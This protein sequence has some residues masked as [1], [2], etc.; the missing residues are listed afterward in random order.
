MKPASH[1]V[2][3]RALAR[4]NPGFDAHATVFDVVGGRLRDRLD[5]LAATPDR[6]LDLGCRTG[7]QLAALA[8]CYP[9]AS[10]TG[11]DPAPAQA[12]RLPSR[13]PSWL[14]GKHT[15]ARCVCAD[16]HA[17][18]FENESFDLVVSNLALPWCESPAQ[19]FREVSRVLAEDGVFFFSAAGPDTLVEYRA[20]WATV[21]AH[22]HAFGLMDMHDL[23]DAMLAAGFADPVL[24][25]DDVT[26]DYPSL[27]ALEQELRGVGAVN[28]AEGRRR[29]L[30][31]RAAR[32][33]LQAQ[34]DAGARFPVTLEL[35]QGHG[36]KVRRGS[37]QSG[38][39]GEHVIP[40]TD[41]IGTLKQ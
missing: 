13:W 9:D 2:V 36:W 35:V 1:A 29:G 21:D 18:P 16:L 4:A 15:R 3:Q 22:P 37:S 23:G 19:I 20:A 40:L 26:V 5:V 32:T 10:I 27:A 24:D 11:V 31:G 8:E 17:L 6:V 14:R 41:L 38:P 7:Y 28:L 30:T 33:R 12:P 39:D 34:V 25:R